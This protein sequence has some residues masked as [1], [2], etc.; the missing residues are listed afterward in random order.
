MQKSYRKLKW[1]LIDRFPA[2]DTKANYRRPPQVIEAY[3]VMP[4]RRVDLSTK[5]IVGVLA[6]AATAIALALIAAGLVVLWSIAASL[7]G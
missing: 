4:A 1:W 7:W 3:R 6:L 2:I 5:V